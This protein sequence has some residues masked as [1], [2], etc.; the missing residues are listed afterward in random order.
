MFAKRL[1]G[2]GLLC[3]L[4]SCVQALG[5]DQDYQLGETGGTGAVA[6][7]G[8]TAGTGAS[9]GSGGVAGM[10]G[11]GG[12]GGAVGG[13]GGAVGGA[14]G[15]V[16]GAGGAGGTGGVGGAVECVTAVDCP[17]TINACVIA[18]CLAGVCGTSNAAAGTTCTPDG[19]VFCDGNGICGE[20]N[21]ASDCA[22]FPPDD[23]CQTRVCDANVCSQA[24]TLAGTPLQ[25]QVAGDCQ[26]TSCDGAGSTVS[27][28]DDTDLPED[29]NPCTQNVC[30]GGVPSYPAEPSGATCGAGL[31]CNGAGVCIGCVVAA[32][33]AGTDDFCK[34]RTCSAGQCGVDLT[35]AGTDLPAANQ[36]S[37][38]CKV[39]ECDAQ[40]NIVT[41]ASNAD[42]PVDGNACTKDLC[43]AG[44]PSNPLE[45]MGTVCD[46]N[47]GECNSMGLCKQGDGTGCMLASQCASNNCV[48]GY[49]C[50]TT[51]TQLC[52]AC[53]VPGALGDCAVVPAGVQDPPNCDG[54]LACDGSSGGNSCNKAANGTPC[55]YPN[56]ASCASGICSVDN[57]CC[58]AACTGQCQ[59]C[60]LPGSVGTCT[61]VP[62]GQDEGT[63][64]GTSSCDGMGGCKKDDGQPCGVGSECSSGICTDGVCCDSVC[65]E[66]C[67][68]CN[69]AGSAGTCSYVLFGGD[70]V[71]ACMGASSCDGFG[72]CKKDNGLSCAVN[73]ECLNG[74]CVDGY[75]CDGTC[76]GT[77]KACNVAGSLGTCSN[78]SSGLDDVPTCSGTSSCDGSGLCKKETGQTCSV[79][80][81]CLTGFCAD[82]YCCNAACSGTCKACNIAGS[83]GTCSNVAAGT[84]DPGTCSGTS[85]CDANGVCKKDNG[86]TCSAANECLSGFCA[87][88]VCCNGACTASCKSCNLAGLQGTCS[89]IVFGQ[90]DPVAVTPCIGVNACDGNGT[91][92]KSNAQTCAVGGECL[93]TFCADGV[94][95]NGACTS[96]CQACNVAGSVGACSNIPSGQDDTN[97]PVTC[98]GVTQSCNGAG[99]CKK[100]LA[101]VCAVG[102]DCLSTFCADGL[103]CDAACGG[104]CQ[105]CTTALKGAGANGTCGPISGGTDPQN[106]CADQGSATCG[107]NGSCSGLGS[108]QLYVSGTQ[109]VAQSCSG[110]TQL[111]ADT[112]NGAGLCLDG[113]SLTCDP[114][115][116]TMS[117]CKLSCASDGDCLAGNYCSAQACLAKKSNG[118][119][120]SATNECTSGFC[121]DGVCCDGACTATCKACNLAGLLGTCSNLGINQEDPVATTT[122]T[123]ALACTGMGLCKLKTGQPCTNNM[124]CISGSCTGNPKVCQ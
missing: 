55:P 7:S 103:C 123:G 119:A 10:A 14:G 49:C 101:Q 109:C 108:C 65:S 23:E 3:A 52:K 51:C 16:G 53:N 24:F 35:P 86:V 21:Q 48:D 44:V 122:C 63:C 41:V 97:A 115:V 93:S 70:D 8:G 59:S 4:T 104:L 9:A 69:V 114:Y 76:T 95:C 22:M 80:G 62:A 120:C 47:G 60:V 57:V 46:A 5:L 112:C 56:G 92:K 107:T 32:D 39:V 113:G 96:T 82:G 18:E 99:A 81:D 25:M 66:T 30:A 73:A 1:L 94:C 121:I 79:N 20:C 64:I 17:P 33:C 77:C 68:A 50:E 90:P 87:D 75:C 110:S 15:A 67:A 6:G 27:D 74:F 78:V 98:A 91:C 83:L 72:T 89:N 42:V 2:L 26:E 61:N 116:C 118:Q 117:A 84:D 28:P 71:P 88:G 29:N 100:E 31:V 34:Q 102:G 38:D 13:A 58:T 37:A 19:T 11:P 85:S 106:E 111:N 45:N 12:A 54:A 43:T 124:D 105:A 36:T 40:G